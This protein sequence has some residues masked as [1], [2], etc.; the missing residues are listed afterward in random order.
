M[1]LTVQVTRSKT[2]HGIRCIIKR[3]VL[4]K[5]SKNRNEQLK[6]GRTGIGMIVNDYV[7]AGRKKL[8]QEYIQGLSLQEEVDGLSVLE[9]LEE[10]DF[11]ALRI[12]R[13]RGKISEVYFKILTCTEL[14]VRP[15][16]HWVYFTRA[17]P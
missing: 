3:N 9:K 7:T 16:K 11:K 6:E 13:W 10:G 1:C 14:L 15:H 2:I 12:K 8:V 17:M 4:P 5:Q